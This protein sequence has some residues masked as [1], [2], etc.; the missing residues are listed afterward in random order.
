MLNSM[1]FNLYFLSYESVETKF[2]INLLIINSYQ[3]RTYYDLLFLQKLKI[4][5]CSFKVLWVLTSRNANVT[6]Q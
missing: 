4:S 6:G 1:G 2:L 5:Y 3:E